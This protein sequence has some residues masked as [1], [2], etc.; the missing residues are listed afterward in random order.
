MMKSFK[1][2]LIIMMFMTSGP[3]LAEN[4]TVKGDMASTIHYELRHQI[5]A[6]DSM[7][8]LMLS[9]V[10]PESFDSPTYKQQISNFKVKF[11]PEAEERT[12]T[13]DAR[14]NKIIEASWTTVP[15]IVDA[16]ISFD[17]QTNT[18]LKLIKSSAPFP[19][20]SI[21]KQLK[22]YL[23]ASELVQTNDPA[24]R[25]LSSKLT[26]GVNTQFE[27]VQKV[28]SFVVDHV[29]YVNPSQQYDALYSLQTGK[30]NCQNYSHLTAALLRNAG[31]PVRIVNGVTMNQPFDVSWAKGTLT[32][33]MGQG[34]HSWVEVWFPDQGWVPYDPQNMQYFIS[35][36]FVRIEVGVDN[37]E[38]KNDGLVR[39]SQNSGART[40][41][42]LQET[43]GG[44]FLAD[45]IKVSAERQN[46][47]PK[48]LLL[49][50]NVLA[51][52]D[53]QPP[54]APPVPVPPEPPAPA[55]PK[56]A[57]PI[58]APAPPPKELRYN[59]PFVFGNLEFPE[60]VDFAFPRVTKARGKNSFEMSRN[61]LVE[62][63]EYVTTG[64]TQYAQVVELAKPVTLHKIVLALH[65]FGGEGWLWVDVFKD[66]EG[67][68]GDLLCKT[69]MINL[70]DISGKPGYRWVDFKFDDKDRPV[71][72]PGAY[73]IALGF[74]G[75]PILNW[76]YT[77]GKP[78]GPVYGTR[79]KS[80]FAQEWS[81][82]LNYEFN[83][84]VVGMTVK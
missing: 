34:R 67:K 38:T 48:N 78:V 24:I 36:R 58:P 21:P 19:P 20:A 66:E 60:N 27:A 57:P 73:W 77:Y 40:K 2:I 68:P 17:A 13:T 80:I 29:H 76:F 45:S 71:L 35:N 1:A 5:T 81:G 64:A 72:K 65:K 41:P 3:A 7:R 51:Q 23:Q 61:F 10:V 18:G 55:P 15:K 33:K 47:G 14:G 31:V 16:I 70:D 30:G 39:W 75:T 74:S 84:K 46:Y 8:K 22:V 63:A 26:K 79:Y 62:T 50:P 54:P 9:F 37:N 43:I 4:F 28:V 12:T 69:Q 59:V 25:E 52:S 56:P 42:T 53:V 11:S 83:Y 32:F 49:G 44:N 6:G 82:A